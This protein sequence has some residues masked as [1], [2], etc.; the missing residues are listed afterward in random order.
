[1]KNKTATSRIKNRD[2][3]HYNMT[4]RRV[5]TQ[6]DDDNSSRILC[7]LSFR[8]NQS[9]RVYETDIRFCAMERS[10][11]LKTLNTHPK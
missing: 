6:E 3:N 2:T 1:M 7:T 9:I 8:G 5:K 11:T 10:D 4:F